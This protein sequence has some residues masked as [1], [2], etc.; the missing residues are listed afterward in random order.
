VRFLEDWARL[1]GGDLRVTE[2]WQVSAELRIQAACIGLG[3]IGD[4]TSVSVAPSLHNVLPGMTDQE[5][6]LAVAAQLMHAQPYLWRIEMEAAADAFELP[7][8]TFTRA[9][10]HAP[11]MY[12]SYETA[13]GTDQDGYLDWMLIHD[14]GEGMLL[15]WLWN[16]S[17]E[18]QTG[19]T[20]LECA[21]LAYGVK[22]PDEIPN[23]IR[24]GID[25]VLKRCAFLHSPYV[26]S[27]ETGVPRGV[28]K[29]LK[30]RGMA[31]PVDSN[32]VR[33]VSLR[34]RPKSMTIRTQHEQ[35][36]REYHHRWWVRPHSRV[37]AKDTDREH[38]VAI[39]RHWKGPAG[40]PWVQP[41][42]YM[43]NR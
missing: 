37:V 22:Y 38:V 35:S 29:D 42:V 13:H 28:R 6:R 9:T 43:V 18:W 30:R 4:S 25:G 27:V 16:Q 36:S 12:W 23:H 3:Q 15:T 5:I 17:L 8:H 33:V 40:A 19:T 10:L 14:A 31:I 24:T 41:K 1:R 21:Y 2:A 26:D 7:P 39:P 20:V 32:Q 34:E 11:T